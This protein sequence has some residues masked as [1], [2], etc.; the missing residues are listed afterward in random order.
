MNESVLMRRAKARSL[1]ATSIWTLFI[2]AVG[3]STVSA[4]SAPESVKILGRMIDAHGGMTTWQSAPTVRFE[5]EWRMGE[6]ESGNP[7]IVTVE[8]GSRRAYIDYSASDMTM[9]WDGS[10]AW[11]KNWQAPT[12]PRFLALLNYYFLNLPWLTQ[13][14]GVIFASPQKARLWDDPIDY[15]A[16][17]MTFAS[18]VGD[19]P[20]DY[21][22]LYIH[23]ETYQLRAC[24][25]IVTYR[26]ILPEG[27][28]A[29]QP[30]ILIY[31]EYATVDGLKVPKHF[32]IYE[33]D[34]SIYAS[35]AIRDWSFTQPFD[36]ARMMMPAN[37]TLDE[38]NP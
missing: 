18:G 1:K 20:D 23:P 4:S 21:Y 11:S 24:E 26:S 6:A 28:S 17:R 32:T 37:A 9:S 25:Y 34:K 35:C 38:S 30:K 2:V 7:S 12:P 29:S 31:N 36:Q 3:S 19:T 10:K 16:I 27:V 13:D 8:Q 22:V 14:P 15:I 5:D 33:L